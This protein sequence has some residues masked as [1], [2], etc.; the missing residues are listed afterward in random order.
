MQSRLHKGVYIGAPL[1][2]VKPGALVETVRYPETFRSAGRR[3]K[4]ARA[5]R[6]SRMTGPRLTAL[7]L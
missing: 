1:V 4:Y 3:G 6:A 5:V 2:D 7:T